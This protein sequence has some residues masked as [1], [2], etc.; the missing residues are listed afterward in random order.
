MPLR[1]GHRHGRRRGQRQSRRDDRYL[2]A[3]RAEED[4]KGHARD[5]QA[6]S[7]VEAEALPWDQRQKETGQ[8]KSR[9]RHEQ[10]PQGPGLRLRRAQSQGNKVDGVAQGIDG[11]PERC[12]ARIRV[13]A[14]ESR[15][16]REE[17]R[18]KE[19]ARRPDGTLVVKRKERIQSFT[20]AHASSLCRQFPS[21]PHART[22]IPLPSLR[23]S[24]ALTASSAAAA[25]TVNSAA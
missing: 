14:V 15:L 16:Q 23:R 3:P 7:R 13:P 20:I 24:R 8:E 25:A 6:W 12:S 9:K 18:S 17:S 19:S 22:N 5:L 21:L 4:D 10:S 11:I 2:A 1:R